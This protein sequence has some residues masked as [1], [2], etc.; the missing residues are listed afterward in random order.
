[1]ESPVV[2]QGDC[3]TRPR[4][5][6]FS[7]F[8]ADKGPVEIQRRQ[9]LIVTDNSFVATSSNL[10]ISKVYVHLTQPDDDAAIRFASDGSPLE[11]PKPLFVRALDDSNLW[12]TE[13]TM[14]GDGTQQV[15][16]LDASS[17]I[18]AEGALPCLI[19]EFSA[20][21]CRS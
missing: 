10:W 16:G 11:W 13:V 21:C 8:S 6:D 17:A 19:R 3:R 20:L 7:L 14:Q 2:L 18:V 4:V 15:K 5:R 12:M 9:C 1:M